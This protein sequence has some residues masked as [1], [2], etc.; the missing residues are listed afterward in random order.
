MRA[1]ESLPSITRLS[2][3]AFGV[4][5]VLGY[6]A[7][8]WAV[9]F[10][11]RLGA[12]TASLVYPLDTFSMYARMP[13]EDRGILL[14]RDARGT[15]HRVTEFRSF[16][17]DQPL[18]GPAARCADKRGI[19]YHYEDFARYVESHTGSGE[20]EVDLITRMC[21]FHTSPPQTSDCVIAHCK[22]AR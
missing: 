7:L 12:Q 10:D 17:C 15:A 3:R 21:D 14:V 19:A 5:C 8:S 18:T 22:V 11:M 1:I 9:R 13:G 6:V 2:R 16:D 4:L 20:H